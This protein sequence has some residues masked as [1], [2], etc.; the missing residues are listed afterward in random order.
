M[1][2]PKWYRDE[3]I[4]ALDLYFNLES[5]GQIH[6]RNPQVIELSEILTKLPIFT[7][8]PD[9]E[10]FRNP[11]GVGLKLSNFLAIDPEYE[12]KGMEAYS[13][14]DEEIF[15]E[16]VHDKN[17]LHQ[18]AEQIK[19]TVANVEVTKRLHQISDDEAD[20]VES[21]KEGYVLY[22]LHKYRE[23]DS[24]ITK[25]KKQLHFKKYGYLKCEV[26]GFDFHKV[27]GKVGK[28][29]IECHHKVPL[30]EFESITETKL[31]DLSLVCANCHRMLHKKIDTIRINDLKALLERK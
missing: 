24:K 13:K 19:R 15:N 18:I 20:E 3:I 5:S 14:L 1:K 10:K 2:N 8:R 7:N 28:G 17:K 31:E 26:C 23:R 30:S 25:Q 29:F 21:V 11:N 6:A 4:L 9:K 12:G 27:Y 16:F 22:K